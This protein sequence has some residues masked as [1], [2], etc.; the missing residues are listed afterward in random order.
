MPFPLPNLLDLSHFSGDHWHTHHNTRYL[1]QPL[2]SSLATVAVIQF[3]GNI[4]NRRP[5]TTTCDTFKEPLHTYYCL[6]PARVVE[7]LG[8]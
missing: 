4:F 7:G 2:D 3:L 8:A 1:E 6:G 5:Y